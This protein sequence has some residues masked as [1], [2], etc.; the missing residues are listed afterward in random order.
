MAIIENIIR[1]IVPLFILLYMLIVLGALNQIH[2][3]LLEIKREI[4]RRK[5]E[6]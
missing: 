2:S 1:V 5:D 3:N 6:N 4:N